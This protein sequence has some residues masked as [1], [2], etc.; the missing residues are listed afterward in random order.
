MKLTVVYTGNDIPHPPDN[1]KSI[2]E[3]RA[4]KKKWKDMDASATD[5]FAYPN[6]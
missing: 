1:L 4:F 3:L 6:D 5:S 2:A